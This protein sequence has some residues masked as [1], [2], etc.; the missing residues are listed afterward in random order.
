M[1]SG[2][3]FLSFSSIKLDI[4]VT[5]VSISLINILRSLVISLV[6]FKTVF[7]TLLFP[8]IEKLND[9]CAFF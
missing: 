6:R 5:T 1:H 3:D 2:N 7:I 8:P 4:Y 9:V